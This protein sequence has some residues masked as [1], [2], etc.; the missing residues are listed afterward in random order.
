MTTKNTKQVETTVTKEPVSFG[1]SF[2]SIL[3]WGAILYT[4]FYFG[5]KHF[6]FWHSDSYE[7][8]YQPFMITLLIC[9]PF[10]LWI[11][12]SIKGKNS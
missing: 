10:G 12:R 11:W 5:R 2:F 6:I 3:F 4:A 8:F 9:F 7:E 1:K